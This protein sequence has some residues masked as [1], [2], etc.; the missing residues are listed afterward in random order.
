M[1]EFSNET[2][3]ELLTQLMDNELDSA[4]EPALYD[5]LANSAELQ[6]EHK[7]HIA[8]REAIKKDSEAFTPPVATVS[9]L[10]NKLGYAPP[11]PAASV[12]ILRK[13]PLL[14]GFLRKAAV[15]FLLLLAGSY[16]AYTLVNSSQDTRNIYFLET[17]SVQS[18]E[19]VVSSD[20]LS[21]SN[22]S[23]KV[24]GVSLVA[25]RKTPIMT[26]NN[27]SNQVVSSINSTVLSSNDI[28]LEK[29]IFETQNANLVQASSSSIVSS[30]NDFA[31]NNY[32]YVAPIQIIPASVDFSN[33]TKSSLTFYVKGMSNSNSNLGSAFSNL[34]NSFDNF[35][36]GVLSKL[37]IDN[38]KAGFEI[39]QQ[40]FMAKVSQS[41]NETVLTNQVQS[42]F[43]YAA[44]AKYDLSFAEL[45]NMQPYFQG[46]F[47]SGNFGKY[48][49]RYSFGVE[50]KPFNANFS[51]IAG[52]EAS[53][54]W[55]STQNI[56]LNALSD[57]GFVGISFGL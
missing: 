51:M 46:S 50:Y 42:V 1:K 18:L 14:I 5:A 12:G 30:R 22:T 39:G 28:V 56:P 19:Q 55:Y 48:M 26:S 27:A 44:T 9:S 43:W 38:L 24:A 31:I 54:L 49:F 37:S 29:D 33:S 52:Y 7:Y 35:S 36:G 57:G 11:P 25:K 41:D 53:R 45:F 20:D 10:F 21:L 13:S 47:G 23:N 4:M 15:P 34:G 2:P 6:E 17:T 8:V 16:G 3:S 40:P 32:N